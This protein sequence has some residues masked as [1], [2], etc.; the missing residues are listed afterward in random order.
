MPQADVYPR[1]MR[2][3]RDLLRRRHH[4]MRKRAEWSAHI[5]QTSSQSHLGDP[6]GR[7]ATPQ[8]RRGLLA[9]FAHRCVQQNMAGDLALVDGDDP[10]LG[11]LERS[12][13]QTAQGHDP[14]ALALWR[15]VPG[16]GNILALVMRYEIEDSARFPRSQACV[17]SG[18]L[19]KSARESN[20]KRHG[21]S[22]KKIGNAH[23]KWAFSEAAVLFLKNNAPA[24]KYLAKLAT[25]HSKGKALSI[26][27]HKLGRA[28]YFMLKNHVAFDQAK[29]LAT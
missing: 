2:A 14:V 28:V 12:I 27:A 19:V 24:Q 4:L 10:L 21:P 18:R 5:Q 11:D 1:R 29:F 9:R 23:L 6:L 7:I 3:T 20:G 16:V 17:S 13:E 22:G 15:T 26:L 8:N 25:R